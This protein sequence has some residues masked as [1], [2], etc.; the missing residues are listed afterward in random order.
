MLVNQKAILK[1]MIAATTHEYINVFQTESQNNC[2]AVVFSPIFYI[3]C[4]I[5]RAFA[6]EAASPFSSLFPGVHNSNLGTLSLLERLYQIVVNKG[7]RDLSIIHKES[8]RREI[9]K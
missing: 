9:I 3:E 1:S 4:E 5:E 6:G 2:I 8:Q 7:S